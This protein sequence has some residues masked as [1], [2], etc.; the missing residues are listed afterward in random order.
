M[1]TL[2]LSEIVNV[3]NGKLFCSKEDIEITKVALK[4]WKVQRGDLYIALADKNSITQEALESAVNNGAIAIITPMKINFKIPQIIV[5]DGWIA[6][7]ILAEYYKNK[8]SIPTIMITGSSGKTSTKDL[9][10]YILSE[11]LKVHKTMENN[12]SNIGVPYT[13]FH[14]KYKHEVS[15]LEVGMD[16]FGQIKNI[17]NYTRPDIAV[18]T[19]IGTAHIEKLGSKENIFKAKMEITE[20]FNENNILIVNADDEYLSSIKEKKYKILKI[21]TKGKG[22]YN[23][24]DIVNLG[25]AGVQFKCKYRNEILL[26]RMNAIG[27]HNIHNALAAIAIGDLFDLDSEQIRRGLL[28]FK[29]SALR[30]KTIRL[31]NNIR[32]IEDCYNANPDSMKYAIDALQ[33]FRGGRKIAVLGDML[34]LGDYSIEAHEELGIYLKNKCDLLVTVGYA[35]KYIFEKAKNHIESKYFVTNEEA[36]EYLNS[37]IMDNDIILVKGSRGMEMEKIVD[38]LIEDKKIITP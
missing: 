15:V 14:M 5:D 33:A 20:G 38:Y 8:F 16:D 34:E 24:F 29:T 32:I 7:D 23:A 22:D 30:M 21:S 27:I 9:I 10:A 1:E 31:A 37:I 36:Y 11:K 19:N 4:S 18:I 25:E 3:V 12:N 2:K 13:I 6:L 28:N 35:S 17:V 26:L